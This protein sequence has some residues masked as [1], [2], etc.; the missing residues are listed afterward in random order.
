MKIDSEEL[1]AAVE[2]WNLEHLR[3]VA[4]HNHNLLTEI[5]DKIEDVAEFLSEH[6]TPEEVGVCAQHLKDIVI[7]NRGER[8]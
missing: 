3:A 6:P 7:E 5:L 2:K 8:E 1:T 4:L